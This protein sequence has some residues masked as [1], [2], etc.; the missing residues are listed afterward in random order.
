MYPALTE[1]RKLRIRTLPVGG[2]LLVFMI[3]MQASAQKT[4]VTVT[5][6]TA[7]KVHQNEIKYVS[8][9]FGKQ[10]YEA[11]CAVCHGANAKGNGPGAAALQPKPADLSTLSARNGGRFPKYHIRY[12]LTDL[13]LYSDHAGS[14]MPSWGP[15]FKSLDKNQ[16]EVVGLR[17]RNLM[18][19]L[20]SMQAPPANAG[21]DPGSSAKPR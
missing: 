5:A 20:E 9:I 18:A 13:D 4:T 6:R 19:Y 21:T 2:V 8:P 17:A 7:P 16:P 14:D 12:L 15:A 10:M 11:Y 1:K 3:T